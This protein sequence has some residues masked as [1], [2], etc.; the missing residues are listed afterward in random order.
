M[1]LLTTAIRPPGASETLSHHDLTA[2]CRRAVSS[3]PASLLA[4]ATIRNH[5]MLEPSRS[6]VCYVCNLKS[7]ISEVN[8]LPLLSYVIDTV[9][10]LKNNVI[11]LTFRGINQVMV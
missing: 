10:E 6:R 8:S 2:C 9:K 3:L 4:I 11:F 7:H 1:W 5:A